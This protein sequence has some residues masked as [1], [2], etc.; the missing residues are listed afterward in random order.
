[1]NCEQTARV[2]VILVAAIVASPAPATQPAMDVV[3]VNPEGFIALIEA[4]F[5]AESAQKAEA[6]VEAAV[7]EHSPLRNPYGES[8][9][10]MRQNIAIALILRD[11]WPG[12][13]DGPRVEAFRDFLSELNAAPLVRAVVLTPDYSGC[14]MVMF[15]AVE[16]DDRFALEMALPANQY[17]GC[18]SVYGVDFKMI[19][20]FALD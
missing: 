20:G 12:A 16:V 11:L 5:G 1:M 9:L 2:L 10:P 4:H 8:F 7:V 15:A 13:L 17:Q 6:K 14:A 19:L 18:P 3:F